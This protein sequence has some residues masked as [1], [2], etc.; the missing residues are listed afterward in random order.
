MFCCQIWSL[1]AAIVLRCVFIPKCCWGSSGGAW[2]WSVGMGWD[3]GWDSV[4]RGDEGG[5]V[6]NRVKSDP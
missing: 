6:V 4:G 5:G 2:G 3:E 1:V